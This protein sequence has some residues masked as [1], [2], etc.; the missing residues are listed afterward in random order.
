M[1]PS[2]PRLWGCFSAHGLLPNWRSVFPTPVGVFLSISALKHYRWRLPHACGGVSCFAPA[3][4]SSD[5][6]SPRLWG[7]FQL[8][9][10]VIRDHLVFPTPVGVFPCGRISGGCCANLPHA[11]GGVSYKKRKGCRLQESSPRLWGCFPHHEGRSSRGLVFPT[12]VGV[13]P[14]RRSREASRVRLPH[15]CGGV[16][17][18]PCRIA[19]SL[20]SSPRLWGCFRCGRWDTGNRCVFPTPVGVFLG[21]T[22]RKPSTCCLPHA[23]GGV[24]GS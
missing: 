23:C 7:C 17:D 6:S 4:V 13:F 11:C 15:A 12:P 8:A 14:G 1:A 21:F 20:A 16:S 9:S 18:W 24:S 10:G 3:M 2:S 19:S 22:S 5:R